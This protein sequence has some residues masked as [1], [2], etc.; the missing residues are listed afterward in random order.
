[1]PKQTTIDNLEK[2]RNTKA[3]LEWWKKKQEYLDSDKIAPH[4]LAD[5]FPVFASRQFVSR[6][7]ETFRYWQ[8]I[9]NIPGNIFECGVADG[10]FMM[11]MAHFSSIYEPHHY[12]RKIIGFD[13]FTG[14]T[15][16]SKADKGSGAAHMKKGGL[17]Y[18]S[19]EYLKKAIEFYDQNRMIGN[20]QKVELVKGDISET[21]PKY[22]KDHPAT[23][24]GLLHLD[25]DLYQPT[26]DVLKIVKNHMAKGSVIVFDEINH[27][28]YPGETLAVMKELKLNTI[29]LK[30]VK[31]AAMA[32]YAIL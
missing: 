16:I 9:E 30:R 15:N 14:F 3:Q 31:E 6:F 20:I 29:N 10:K 13:T 8:L 18:Y 22:L 32:G 27:D 2:K 24:I 12:T 11:S 4:Q 5:I 26:L 7:L 19:F 23:V 25:L 17:Y 1:M 28:D 21:L